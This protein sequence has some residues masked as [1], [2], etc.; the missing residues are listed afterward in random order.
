MHIYILRKRTVSPLQ[1]N[2][3]F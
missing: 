2:F 3:F 1:A